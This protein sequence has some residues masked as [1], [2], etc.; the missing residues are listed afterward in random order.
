MSY[1]RQEQHAECVFPSSKWYPGQGEP[2]S[3]RGFPSP[4]LRRENLQQ[5]A[6][7]PVG[8]EQRLPVLRYLSDWQQVPEHL[9]KQTEVRPT[10]LV[11]DGPGIPYR[12]L[13]VIC[14][15]GRYLAGARL[16]FRYGCGSSKAHSRSG[17]SGRRIERGWDTTMVARCVWVT[18]MRV[19]RWTPFVR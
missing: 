17:S 10:V 5:P 16:G 6:Y 13:P 2:R 8:S 19:L 15:C 18:E 12:R 7:N 11:A 3:K 1:D 14:R 4:V 9:A